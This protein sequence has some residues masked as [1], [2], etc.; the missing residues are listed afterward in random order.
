LPDL[1]IATEGF[2]WVRK[3][4]PAFPTAPAR[5]PGPTTH[6]W[7]LVGGWAGERAG[8]RDREAGS[9]GGNMVKRMIEAYEQEHSGK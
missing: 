6:C 9:I 7:Y 3:S 2:C 5:S 8:G 1:A 4:H